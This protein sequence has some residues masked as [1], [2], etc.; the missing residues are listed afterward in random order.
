M[1][2]YQL[3]RKS[4]LPEIGKIPA[5]W[6]EKRA[7]YFF[8]EVVEKSGAGS[9]ELL[10]VSHITGVTPRK[11]NVTMFMAESYEGYKT[12]QVND[13]VINIMWAWMGGLGVSRYS[14]IVS[15]AY[16]V[17]RLRDSSCFE[18]LYLNYLLRIPAYISEYYRHSKGI[19]SSRLRMYSDEFFNIPIVCPPLQEQ[20]QIV[21]FLDRKLEQINQFIRNKQR[22]IELLKKQKPTLINH[23]VTNGTNPGVPMKDSGIAWIGEIPEHWSV[24]KLKNCI[25]PGTSISYGILQPG[26]HVR[27]G[28][29]FVQTTNMTQGD[30]A[31]ESLPRTERS[32]A[33]K[34]PRSTLQAGDIMLNIRASIGD[35]HIVPPHLT[36]ANL[37]R[38]VAR[39][40]VGNQLVPEFAIA[41]LRSSS[42]AEYWNI[43]QQGTTF[44]EVSIATVRE[45]PVPVPP[46]CEQKKIIEVIERISTKVDAAIVKAKREIALI[47]EYCATLISD[48]VIGKIDVC[49]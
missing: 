36:G 5:Y 33:A 7:K 14:G 28:I 46:L 9:E 42:A 13:V 24:R 2:G 10:S 11:E 3:Y 43:H 6:K 35:A 22:L 39:I 47:Q 21:D 19:R 30:F 38:G 45:L 20:K 15:S 17:Y 40:V 12:C 8:R 48:S 18:P 16:G 4:K 25:Y 23:A 1:K 32:I 37:S 41:Y 27:D 44:N 34:Y 26:N 31:L 29:P 49:D